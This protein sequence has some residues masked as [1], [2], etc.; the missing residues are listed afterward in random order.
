[1]GERNGRERVQWEV[2]GGVSWS[3]G[4]QSSRQTRH[5]KCSSE[6]NQ[7]SCLLLESQGNIA[8]RVVH[9]NQ[10]NIQEFLPHTFIYNGKLT[11][12]ENDVW[13]LPPFEYPNLA[14]VLR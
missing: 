2:S 8:L 14:K 7:D 1:M 10:V 6:T 5:Q 4:G 9:S 3:L 13:G 11:E 12:G